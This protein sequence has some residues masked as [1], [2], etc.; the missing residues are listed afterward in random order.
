MIPLTL[1][2]ALCPVPQEGSQTQMTPRYG[3]PWCCCQ[4]NATR[5]AIRNTEV[6]KQAEL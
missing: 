5:T 3:V 4:A 6:A 1:P 2:L